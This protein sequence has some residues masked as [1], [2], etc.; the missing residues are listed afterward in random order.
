MS[1]YCFFILED[2]TILKPDYRHIL[3]VKEAPAAFGETDE[4][5]NVTFDKWGEKN[6]HNVESNARQ[7]IL[8]RVINRN[9]IRIRKNQSKRNQ[10]WSIQLHNLTK[11]KEEAIFSWASYIIEKEYDRYGTV[12]IHQFADGSKKIVFINELADKHIGK[13]PKVITQNELKQR[14]NS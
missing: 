14:Y 1:E 11:K 3:A 13:T 10:N 8:L 12:V 5:L 6:N 7:E 4:S 2:E 9:I